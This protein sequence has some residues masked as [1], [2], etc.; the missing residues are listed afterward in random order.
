MVNELTE[1][2]NKFSSQLQLLENQPRT[3]AE[4]KGQ[5]SENLRISEKEKDNNE[6]I[7]NETDIKIEKLRN[8]LN[9]IQE[10]SIQIRE[11]KASSS[12][13]I[14]GLAKRKSDLFNCL[15][16]KKKS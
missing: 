2:K 12:A 15:F 14:E 16:I 1:R 11:R 10:Q 8:E 7:I 3:Q 6:I 5:I 13:T 9:A 4:K